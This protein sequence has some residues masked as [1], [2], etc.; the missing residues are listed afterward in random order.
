MSVDD[1]I[2]VGDFGHPTIKLYVPT[3]VDGGP[4]L[5]QSN[6][7]VVAEFLKP[8]LALDELL[9][10]DGGTFTSE[11]AAKT[12]DASEDIDL[13]PND[14]I[15]TNDALYFGSSERF[16]SLD[17]VIGQPGVGVWELTWEY[18][19]GSSWTA[20]SGVSDG[21][22]DFK[23]RGKNRVEWTLP[24]DWEKVVVNDK[25][26]YWARARVSAPDPSP[27]TQPRGSAVWIG[28][29]KVSGSVSDASNGE[30]SFTIPV[31]LY[32]EPGRYRAQAVVMNGNTYTK[33]FPTVEIEV[34]R[35]FAY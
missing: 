28:P 29:V 34:R 31:G 26:H 13:L 8:T 9:L 4:D 10:D 21:T 6:V 32:D 16:G 20:L 14:P 12:E 18:W 24:T 11:T 7:S 1:P 22:N 15:A 25:L 27:T 23:T 19:N 5:T 3:L 30:L 35:D 33:R 17:V 2:Y